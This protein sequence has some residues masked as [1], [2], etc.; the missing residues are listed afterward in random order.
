MRE[1]TVADVMTRHVITAVP[2]TPFK[3]LVRM[4]LAHD[5]DALPVIDSAGRTPH[6]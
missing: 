5:I 6:P 1:S 4:L 2:D 3:E